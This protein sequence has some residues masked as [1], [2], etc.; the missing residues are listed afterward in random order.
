MNF[1]AATLAAVF[2]GLASLAAA[3]GTACA[4]CHQS[5]YDSYR[6]NAMANSSVPVPGGPG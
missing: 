4:P 6:R 3:P 5:I 2:S 1:R